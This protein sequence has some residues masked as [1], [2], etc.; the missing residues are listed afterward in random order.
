MFTKVLVAN[1]GEIAVRLIRAL[2]E[3][4]IE[5]VAIYSEADRDALHVRFADEAY[6]VGPPASGE[7]YLVGD[8]IVEVTSSSGAE[9]IHPGYG[10]LA[11]NAAFANMV[12]EAGLA[13]I[14]PPPS[15]IEL[16]GSKL[17]SRKAAMDAG[18]P[19]IPGSEASLEE[20][21]EV[22]AEAERLGYPVL[23]KADFGAGRFTPGRP[24]STGELFFG[25][26]DAHPLAATASRR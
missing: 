19:T 15:A 26:D 16:M 21:A 8:R 17:A 14:G 2:R 23:L 5:S 25:G 13:W 20:E 24:E 3:M 9:A 22:A 1:R 4:E 18:V 12:E 7:S 11:E 10:F 6:C